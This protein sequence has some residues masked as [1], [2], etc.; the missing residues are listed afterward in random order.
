M[1]FFW[2]II[3]KLIL[4]WSSHETTL[5]STR[6]MTTW[7]VKI[8]LELQNGRK[9]K[10]SAIYHFHIDHNANCF[11]PSPPPPLAPPKKMH[12]HCLIVLISWDDCNTQEKLQTMIMQNLGGGGGGGGESW[13]LIYPIWSHFWLI[14]FVEEVRK[15][16]VKGILSVRC[17]VNI[18]CAKLNL[19]RVYEWAICVM[20]SFYYYDQNLSGFF[21]LVQ[22]RGFVIWTLLG[23]PNLNMKG[24]TKRIL[25]VVVK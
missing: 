5:M 22:I 4:L 10:N 16:H 24:K 21:F 11:P 15:D 6:V 2:I 20:T 7:S 13:T 18:F 19:L 1:I 25:V 17:T 8:F 14:E 12:N 23:L 9:T 3:K